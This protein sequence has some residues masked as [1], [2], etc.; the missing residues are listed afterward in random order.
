MDIIIRADQTKPGDH[1]VSID[2]TYNARCTKVVTLPN[3]AI[4]IAMGKKSRTV[5]PATE[6][7]VRR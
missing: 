2:H 5:Q 7:T 6:V 3:G 4:E 1:V